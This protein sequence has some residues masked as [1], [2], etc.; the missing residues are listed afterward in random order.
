MSGQDLDVPV[1]IVGGGYAGLASSAFLAAQGVRSLLVDRHPGIPIQGRARGINPRTMELYRPLGIEDAVMAAGAPFDGEAGVV[2]CASIAGEWN[3]L[4]DD[5]H[6]LPRVMP[7]RTAARFCMA[8]QSSVEPILAEAARARGAEHWTDT[9]L[10][11]LEDGAG[12]MTAVLEDRKTGAH[13]RVRAE[14]VIAADGVHSTVRECRGIPRTGPG[15]TQHWA[16]MIV[17]ADLADLVRRRA[18]FWIVVN[19]DIGFGA[20]LTTAGQDHWAVS[21]TYDPAKESLADFTEDRCV[22]VA[23]SV[24]GDPARAVEIL[25]L[26]GWEEAVAVAERFRDDRVFLVGDSAHV[27]PPAGAMGANSAVQ[28]AHNLAWK[29]AAVLRGHAGPGLLD[30]YEAERRPVATELAR[31]VVRRQETRFGA[32]PNDDDVDDALCVFGQRYRS[33]A[34]LGAEHGSVFGDT[35]DQYASPGTRAP[36][37]WLDGAD[38]RIGVHD[39]CLDAFV[40]LTGPGGTRWCAAAARIRDVPLRAYRVGPAGGAAELIDVEGNW[41]ARYRAAEDSAVLLRPDGYVAWRGES[42]VDDAEGALRAALRR[43]LAR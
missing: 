18:L 4:L 11:S 39:L 17:R 14:Y 41:A 28:D 36:H 27:W 30:S 43:V 42:E 6:G 8:D 21:V 40:L 24:I 31:I 3:W 29:L 16:S 35:L 26:T 34:V 33:G 19:E 23:R 7:D 37:L 13:R 25:D 1:L 5:S 12:R 38:G 32:T 15:T 10:L 22:R 20:F 9:R 2:R